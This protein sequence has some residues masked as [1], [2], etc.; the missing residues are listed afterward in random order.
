MA[1]PYLIGKSALLLVKS[2]CSKLLKILDKFLD[3]PLRFVLRTSSCSWSRSFV[4]PLGSPTRPVAPPI[5]IRRYEETL[6]SQLSSVQN[7]RVGKGGGKGWGMMW[8]SVVVK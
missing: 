5:C 7:E 4:R 2:N 3:S 8:S 6:T 1:T